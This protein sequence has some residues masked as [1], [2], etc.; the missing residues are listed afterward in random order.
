VL[1]NAGIRIWLAERAPT[2]GDGIDLARHAIDSGA[3]RARLDSIR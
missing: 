1:L 3:A 2:I